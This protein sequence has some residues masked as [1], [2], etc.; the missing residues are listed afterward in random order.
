MKFLIPPHS[1]NGMPTKSLLP[2]IFSGVLLTSLTSSGASTGTWTGEAG[3]GLWSSSGNWSSTATNTVPPGSTS[4]TTDTSTAHFSNTSPTVITVDANRNLKTIIFDATGTAS[5][6]LTGGS[7]LLT[8]AGVTTDSSAANMIINSPLVIQNLSSGGAGTYQ[9]TSSGSSTTNGLSIGGPISGS[10]TS[11]NTST[12]TL[13]GTNTATSATTGNVVSG[14]ISDG[15]GGGSLALTKSTTGQWDLTANNTFTGGVTITSGTLSVQ[16]SDTNGASGQSVAVSKNGLGSGAVNLNGASLQLLANGFGDSSSQVI[17]YGNNLNVNTGGAIISVGQ[18]TAGGASKNK[19]IALGAV[20]VAAG[21]SLTVN[22]TDGYVLGLGDTTLA[23]SASFLPSAGGAVTIKSVTTS[24]S[25]TLTL[26]GSGT[27]KVTGAVS[28]DAADSTKTLAVTVSGGGTWTL[29]GQNT[30]TGATTVSSS[31]LLVNGAFSD[32]TPVSLRTGVLGT[33]HAAGGSFNNANPLSMTSLTLQAGTVG[34]P[35][36]ES[37]LK[38]DLGTAGNNDEMS[39]GALSVG[40]RMALDITDTT[41]SGSDSSLSGD[42]T[43]LTW[44]AGTL[45]LD[46]LDLVGSSPDINLDQ[47]SI[48]GDS[49]VFTAAEVPEPS[50]FAMLLWGL[51]LCIVVTRRKASTIG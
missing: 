4:S 42:Y 44:S 7:L 2:L 43:L 10:A 8:S 15:L 29:S 24:A 39:V 11:G 32:S 31:T 51:S 20:N 9:M 1:K 12:L 41:L 40:G 19:T 46:Q 23:G 22:G 13:S 30:Y 28:D 21:K 37:T 26:G 34:S 6:T 25:G 48:V 50:A 27:G 49:L 38:F 16:D 47:F 17:T 3:D 14:V 35:I 36:P 5:T 45:T 33:G 18:M